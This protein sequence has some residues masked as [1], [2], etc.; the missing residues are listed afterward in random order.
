MGLFR[1]GR[2]RQ[3]Q[4]TD[5]PRDGLAKGWVDKMRMAMIPRA[6]LW[7]ICTTTLSSTTWFL[8]LNL[9]NLREA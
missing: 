8:D 6:S 1:T 9:G 3:R 7:S 4:T 5:R 2:G